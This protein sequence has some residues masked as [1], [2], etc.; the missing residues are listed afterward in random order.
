MKSLVSEVLGRAP[1]NIIS[2]LEDI[3]DSILTWESIFKDILQSHMKM[4]IGGNS[5]PS[6][7]TEIRKVMNQRHKSLK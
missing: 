5:P 6:I 4:K 7:N 2:S 3:N 1:T